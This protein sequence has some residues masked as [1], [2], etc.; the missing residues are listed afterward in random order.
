[1][2]TQSSST[3][4]KMQRV[5]QMTLFAGV[6]SSCVLLLIGSLLFFHSK[7]PVPPNAPNM[8]RLLKNIHHLDGM[9]VAFAGLLVLMITPVARMAILVVGFL[10]ERDWR[11][12]LVALV[13]LLLLM[14]SGIYSIG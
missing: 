6:V 9:H 4:D 8:A 5:V 3:E 13:V 1:M 10:L 14:I 11:F 12:L 7:T 2:H